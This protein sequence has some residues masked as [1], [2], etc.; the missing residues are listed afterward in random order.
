MSVTNHKLL[1]TNINL[2][3]TTNIQTSS[4]K[5]I[6]RILNHEIYLLEQKKNKKNKIGK[7]V[8]KIINKIILITHK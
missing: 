1:I 2:R 4:S 7:N 5:N 3:F 6:C 8:L